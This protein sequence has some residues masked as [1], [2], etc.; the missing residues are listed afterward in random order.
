MESEQFVQAY[1]ENLSDRQV[2]AGGHSKLITEAQDQSYQFG[3]L[4]HA[5]LAGKT[6]DVMRSKAD[7]RSY[8]SWTKGNLELEERLLQDPEFGLR[9][10]NEVNFH[11]LN[12]AMEDMW[13]P[14]RFGKWRSERDACISRAQKNLATRAVFYYAAREILVRDGGEDVLFT[15][16]AEELR[17]T[18]G[19]V[20]QELD[21][22][23]VLLE[24]LRLNKKEHP[25]LTIVPAPLNFERSRREVNV[26]FVAVD[27][28]ARRAVG[29]QVKSSARGVRQGQTDPE[30]VVF[31]D[32]STDFDNVRALRTNS[33]KSDRK[34]VSWSGLISAA[35]VA[36]APVGSGREQYGGVQVQTIKG[37]AQEALG[38][39]DK[40]M[41]KEAARRISSRILDKL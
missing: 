4:L 31:V 13:E 6:P 20:I 28:M 18:I 23:V 24:V 16:E 37:I 30:R 1:P 11:F 34:V 9:A 29:I 22:G 41:H 39:N 3:Q 15:D 14:I 2:H 5:H 7:W 33:R 35:F 26:D 8:R 17:A 38:E 21:A 40:P 10:L 25:N 36:N 27:A 32:G 19:G 12:A